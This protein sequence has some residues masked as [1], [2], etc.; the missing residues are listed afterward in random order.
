MPEPSLSSLSRAWASWPRPEPAYALW[1]H[2]GLLCTPAI[3]SL[4]NFP[5]E[6]V[7]APLQVPEGA[8]FGSSSCSNNSTSQVRIRW[9]VSTLLHDLRASHGTLSHDDWHIYLLPRLMIDWLIDYAILG[10]SSFVSRYARKRSVGLV[11]DT[12]LGLTNALYIYL[13]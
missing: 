5:P 11:A 12:A 9:A 2:F 4:P 7:S 8:D 10:S 1:I 13:F 3:I 6:S